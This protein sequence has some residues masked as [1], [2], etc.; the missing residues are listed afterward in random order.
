ML[1]IT[2]TAAIIIFLATNFPVGLIAVY[3]RY[4]IIAFLFALCL[5][6]VSRLR[7]GRL[8]AP[9]FAIYLYLT[10]ALITAFWT[11]NVTLSLA[12]W[13]LYSS[14]SLVFLTAGTMIGQSGSSENPFDPLKWGFV[15]MLLLSCVSLVRGGGWVENNF[16][17]I[18][19]N[20][21]ALGASL[22]LTSPWLIYELRRCWKPGWRRTYLLGLTG[23]LILIMLATH[24]RAALGALVVITFF[25]VRGIKMRRQIVLA[26]SLVLMVVLT[27][28]FRPQ[29]FDFLAQSYVTKRADTIFASRGQQMEDSWEAAKQGGVLGAG[30]GVSIG[31]SRYWSLKT[32]SRL[33][34][35]KGNSFLAI[36]EE[37]GVI[38]LVLYCAMLCCLLYAIRRPNLAP[39]P[40][41]RFIINIAT[42]Y[43]L[44][45][46]LHG[47]F[48]AW[49]L[50]FGPDISVYW[51][52][53]GLAIGAISRTGEQGV[54]QAFRPVV[55]A[56]GQG[57]NPAGGP[58]RG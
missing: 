33:A 27:Y 9:M 21:N 3:G 34:R 7:V 53:L 10:Y 57:L 5:F 28:G 38:G 39:D 36:V 42:G 41:R 11:E 22:M 4:P 37:T 29:T 18:S 23:A 35:E 14:V 52:T 24:S 56:G 19:G 13:V 1:R 54:R 17:G 47:Q 50:S 51:A 2:F 25:A 48:E 8:A 15:P 20:A 32:I 16:R 31:E 43:F 45:A 30:F 49:F 26:Y 40:D 46:L 55:L 44:G 6:S 12:R 58:V